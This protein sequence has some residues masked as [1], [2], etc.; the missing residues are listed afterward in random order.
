MRS[1]IVLS[2]VFLLVLS[3]PAIAQMCPVERVPTEL[4]M[5]VDRNIQS[6]VLTATAKLSGIDLVGKA[7]APLPLEE[8]YFQECLVGNYTAATCP[9]SAH[10]CAGPPQDYW[11]CT[12]GCC[13]SNIVKKT[14]ADGIAIALFPLDNETI[15]VGAYMG[16]DVYLP[17]NSTASYLY[18]PLFGSLGIT[19]CF[20]LFLILGLLIM[21]MNAMGQSPLRAFDFSSLRAPRARMRGATALVVGTGVIAGAIAAGKAIGKAGELKKME[22]E[23][24]I[25]K[26]KETGRYEETDKGKKAGIALADGPGGTQTVH[27]RKANLKKLEKEGLIRKN[28]VTGKYEITEAGKK[29]GIGTFKT[30]T[31]TTR[32]YR[33][34]TDKDGNVAYGFGKGHIK[35]RGVFG[36]VIDGVQYTAGAGFARNMNLT[37]G[38]VWGAIGDGAKAG[39]K[40]VAKGGETVVNAPVGVATGGKTN[41]VKLV[42]KGLKG[43]WRGVSS[44]AK[45]TNKSLGGVPKFIV[46]TAPKGAYGVASGDRAIAIDVKKMKKPWKA[47]SVPKATDIGFGVSGKRAEAVK[48]HSLF[49]IY[50][51]LVGSGEVSDLSEIKDQLKIRENELV[52]LQTQGFVAKKNGK[53]VLTKLGEEK[54]SRA[55]DMVNG[56]IIVDRNGNERHM[57]GVGGLSFSVLEGIADLDGKNVHQSASG[58][59][60]DLSSGMFSGSPGK[61]VVV[62]RYGKIKEVD[63]QYVIQAPPTPGTT[64]V[65]LMSA[66]SVIGPQGSL[67]GS[68]YVMK[69]GRIDE[70]GGSTFGGSLRV[71][72]GGGASAAGYELTDDEK[73][74]LKKV[75]KTLSPENLEA[76]TNNPA[77]WTDPTIMALM[78]SGAID[79]S[80]IVAM[81]RN[82]QIQGYRQAGLIMNED[83]L[84]AMEV[85]H[86]KASSLKGND[87]VSSFTDQLR[88]GVTLNDETH[89][90]FSDRQ[91]QTINLALNRRNKEESLNAIDTYYSGTAD[92]PRQEREMR[93]MATEM[94]MHEIRG[95]GTSLGHMAQ[96]REFHQK[97]RER[98]DT[99]SQIRDAERLDTQTPWL[100]KTYS[101]MSASGQEA[102]D[103]RF[104]TNNLINELRT[105]NKAFENLRYAEDRMRGTQAISKIRQDRAQLNSDIEKLN[106]NIDNTG[107]AMDAHPVGSPEFN[108]ANDEFT[109]KMWELHGEGGKTTEMEQLNQNAREATN[110]IDN[111][112]LRRHHNEEKNIDNAPSYIDNINNNAQQVGTSAFLHLNSTQ[113]GNELYSSIN[114]MAREEM[115]EEVEEKMSDELQRIRERTADVRTLGDTPAVRDY[116]V[117]KKLDEKTEGTYS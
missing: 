96:D 16:G 111:L 39:A 102:H 9:A 29:A 37:G 86:E 33:S 45:W 63:G 21:S 8:I 58:V 69:F 35:G 66:L 115:L 17:S 106:A 87:Y 7:A 56:K 90:Q 49:S 48:N 62:E 55:K 53:W 112:W 93:D 95:R 65:A 64:T 103:V 52:R 98:L 72:G 73:N 14:D 114:N 84:R 18:P 83:Q 41:L 28:T 46:W 13:R 26:N 91:V 6:G 57:R 19:A 15:I 61:G 1:G 40:V 77:A 22:K 117:K 27:D 12:T 54:S 30:N 88:Q 43:A 11:E 79:P 68:A 38:P 42:G 36:K 76:T 99:E 75:E 101:I 78:Q 113:Q 116:V 110:H 92:L 23:G 104:R 109:K 20:P 67:F 100:K 70:I 5:S 94:N 60:F 51:G 32:F 4:D 25:A 34:I 59:P 108:S 105:E 24:L 85:A 107:A 74:E 89:V 71:A 3:A 97:I 81:G 47:V 80:K 31:G 50:S 44:A 10:T 82:T 2:L